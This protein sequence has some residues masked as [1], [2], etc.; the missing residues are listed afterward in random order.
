MAFSRAQRR[1]SR[2]SR[3]N[4]WSKLTFFL[5]AAWAISGRGFGDAPGASNTEAERLV[6]AAAEAATSGDV[7]KSIALLA[8]AVR[9]DPDNRLARWQ[10]G[11]IRTNKKWLKVEEAQQQAASDRLQTQ[12]LKLR[13]ASD[14]LLES[15]LALAQWCTKRGLKDEARYHWANVLTADPSNKPA[16]RALDV[17]WVRGR[18][19]TAAQ[20]AADKSAE[21]ERRREHL[22]FRIRKWKDAVAGTNNV[23]IDEVLADIRL[24][25]FAEA[26]PAVENFIEHPDPSKTRNTFSAEL[27]ALRNRLCL[28]FVDALVKM[29]EQAATEALTRQAVWSSYGDVQDRAT[30][31][32]K[33]RPRYDYVPLLIN[34]LDIT[35]KTQ[36]ETEIAQAFTDANLRF[37]N[38]MMDRNRQFISAICP[39]CAAR[40]S[41]QPVNAF[42]PRLSTGP[43][44][45]IRAN[46][47]LQSMMSAAVNEIRQADKNWWTQRGNKQFMAVLEKTTDQHLGD[48][49]LAW[50]K[51]W[52]NENDYYESPKQDLYQDYHNTVSHYS[53]SFSC[54]AKGT[55]V[56]TKSG[57]RAI[58]SLEAGDL[59]LS[60]N[61]D[62]GE[63]GYK[64]VL[65]R[66]VRPPT[67][68]LKIACDGEVL[69]TTKGHP[70]WVAG[71][72]W[73]MAKELDDGA[74]LSGLHGA[75][76]VRSIEPAGEAEAYNLVVAEF[77][78]YFVG[79]SGI[80]V[81][82]N[83]P[84]RP[85][86][87]VL[88]GIVKK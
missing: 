61:V 28:A 84:R 26:I 66:T 1:A 80:L 9:I 14:D 65:V 71:T 57:Q 45:M 17:H 69:N 23:W 52:Q 36:S 62:T 55:P 68:I 35:V 19:M 83:T 50:W 78:T 6:A 72:G 53:F 74:V 13:A 3:V 40:M 22:V 7:A 86:Q 24:I 44:A 48:D 15:Q 25:D 41:N 81:H 58:E 38:N 85:T 2:G 73:R 43:D 27:R 63:L 37:A 21:R 12:Y 16:Q 29:P 39:N 11:E 33:K 10:L 67:S 59:V 82:D 79:D 54:F 34:G 18:L 60:Q 20:I 75:S 77:N 31:E 46:N 87:A 64:P 76:K 5:V 47:D 32:L 42:S 49:P 51:W 70:F 4:G 88:P 56:W 8:D 30:A